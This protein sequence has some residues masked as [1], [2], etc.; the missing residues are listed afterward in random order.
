MVV[1]ED[2]SEGLRL[3]EAVR[4]AVFVIVTLCDAETDGLDEG[5]GEQTLP[6]ASLLGCRGTLTI[7]LI[8]WAAVSAT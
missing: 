2:D 6:Q 8:L 3:G 4:V 1:R 7:F 5:L